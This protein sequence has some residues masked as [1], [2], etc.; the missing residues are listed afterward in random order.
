M[1]EVEVF[2]RPSSPQRQ[3]QVVGENGV[4][5]HTNANPVIPLPSTARLDDVKAIRDDHRDFILSAVTEIQSRAVFDEGI[6]SLS[7]LHLRQE[8][9]RSHWNGFWVSGELVVPFRPFAV[10]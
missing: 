1:G 3:T 2:G 4:D 9:R 6:G 5:R 8:P 10:L 7:G